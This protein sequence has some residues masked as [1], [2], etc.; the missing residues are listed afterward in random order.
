MTGR[1]EPL[2]SDKLGRVRTPV[3]KR[4]EILDAFERSSVS[5][6]EFARLT[7]IKAPT[8]AN[9]VRDWP[10]N[11][12]TGRRH[13]RRFPLPAGEDQGEGERPAFTFGHF[14]PKSA[15]RHDELRRPYRTACPIQASRV[16]ISKITIA[17]P[18]IAVKTSTSCS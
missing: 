2:K 5:A 14:P 7:G 4:E 1:A 8:P 11:L 15:V 17:L 13:S 12:P 18:T 10:E 9:W 16:P 3:A 6:A